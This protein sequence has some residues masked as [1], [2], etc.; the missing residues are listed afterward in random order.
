MCKI[1][2][3]GAIRRGESPNKTYYKA[4]TIRHIELESSKIVL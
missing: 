3:V 1:A 4:T 2:I